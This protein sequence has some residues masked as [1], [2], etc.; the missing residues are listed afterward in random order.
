LPAI[1][2]IAKKQHNINF[3]FS[4]CKGK[5]NQTIVD[6]L[7]LGQNKVGRWRNRYTEDGFRALEKNLPCGKN[8]GGKSSLG[9]LRLRNKVIRMTTQ[10]KPANGTHWTTFLLAKAL[11]TTDINL[12]H[13]LS[14]YLLIALLI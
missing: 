3:D 8:H 9:Q 14:H 1:S 13:I 7:G 11:N 6:E 5:D 4:I 10:E 12:L 2:D